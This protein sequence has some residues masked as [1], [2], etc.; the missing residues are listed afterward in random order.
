MLAA[1][2]PPLYPFP[3]TTFFNG[4]PDLLYL[5]DLLGLTY[6]TDFTDFTGLPDLP[7]LPDLP[8]LSLAKFSNWI[9]TM[10]RLIF[11]LHYNLTEA[12]IFNG[13]IETEMLVE[14]L[15]KGEID[16]WVYKSV[17]PLN[18]SNYW[19]S[20]IYLFLSFLV[21]KSFLFI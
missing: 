20:E 16:Q 11:Q 14:V 19:I 12:R 21:F 9:I 10:S 5:T 8:N 6:L 4:L 15:S 17:M 1:F 2:L 7:D 13:S 3:I 18:Q